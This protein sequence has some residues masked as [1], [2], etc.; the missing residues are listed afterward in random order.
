MTESEKLQLEVTYLETMKDLSEEGR[1]ILSVIRDYCER[2]KGSLRKAMKLIKAREKYIADLEL[3][4]LEKAYKEKKMK[5]WVVMSGRIGKPITEEIY[6]NII[7]T[8]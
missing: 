3:L 8:V 5:E 6:K 7:K 2:K 1:I 4:L